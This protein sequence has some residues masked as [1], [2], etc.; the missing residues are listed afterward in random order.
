M[1]DCLPRSLVLLAAQKRLYS[2][3]PLMAHHPRFRLLALLGCL[4]QV[5]LQVERG[6][7]HFDLNYYRL[8]TVPSPDFAV[9]L[10]FARFVV[11]LVDYYRLARCYRS[12]G[13]LSLIHI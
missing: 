11:R 8:E 9:D 10:S 6:W 7:R 4:A 12:V 2:V 5:D 13:C 3:A 1:I